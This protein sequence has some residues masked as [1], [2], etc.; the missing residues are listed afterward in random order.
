M[1]KSSTG[2]IQPK[3]L[4]KAPGC[5]LHDVEMGEYRLT[6]TERLEVFE[7]EVEFVE[8]GEDD[9]MSTQTL[10]LKKNLL[11]DLEKHLKR[12]VKTL[13]VFSFNRRRYDLKLIKS[14]LIPYIYI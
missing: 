10:R 3:K 1:K 5:F 8:N 12:Y 2:S 14:Y 9:D 11:I 4:N 7:Y 13:P 6:S